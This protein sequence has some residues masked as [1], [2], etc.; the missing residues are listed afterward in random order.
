MEIFK[1]LIWEIYDFMCQPFE[2]LGY[3]IS[4]MSIFIVSCIL[5]AI[6]WLFFKFTE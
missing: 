6:G 5:G 1:I 4:F 3:E 2:V